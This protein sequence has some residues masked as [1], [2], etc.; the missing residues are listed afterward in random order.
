MRGPP[1]LGDAELEPGRVPKGS[2]PMDVSGAVWWG[3]WVSI[4]A[5]WDP[6]I[7]TFIS[8]LKCVNPSRYPCAVRMSPWQ[9]VGGDSLGYRIGCSSP[10]QLTV[11]MQT[12]VAF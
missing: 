3:T 8:S 11:L 12:M 5:P 4:P 6:T 10:R 2:E 7:W 9:Y 1:N